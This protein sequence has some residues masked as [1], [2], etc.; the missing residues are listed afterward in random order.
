MYVPPIPNDSGV[1]A[2]AAL[3]TLLRAGKS[4]LLVFLQLHRSMLYGGADASLHVNKLK[5]ACLCGPSLRHSDLANFTQNSSS[6]T[7][8]LHEGCVRMYV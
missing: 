8:F 3:V 6:G 4:L 2:G 5:T 7:P 1:A